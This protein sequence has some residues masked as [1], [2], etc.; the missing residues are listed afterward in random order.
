[1]SLPRRKLSRALLATHISTAAAA[2]LVAGLLLLA[3]EFLSLRR[4]L[5]NDMQAHARIISL[6]SSAAVVFGDKAAAAETLSALNTL[7]NLRAAVIFDANG[8]RIAEHREDRKVIIDPPDAS[9]LRDTYRFGL[10]SLTVVE[11]ILMAGDRVGAVVINSGLDRLYARV[12][13]FGGVFVVVGL[14]GLLASFPLMKRMSGQIKSAE[15]RLDHL[16]HFDPVT[17]LLNRNAFNEYLQSESTA[18]MSRGKQLGLLLLDID[19]FKSV[20]DTFGHQLGDQLLRQI[21]ERLSA[22]VRDGD[23]VFRIGGDEF[24]VAFVRIDS[25]ERAVEIT[26]RLFDQFTRRFRLESQEIEAAVSGGIS[27]Y[28]RDADSI[29]AL[30][31]NA[32]TAMYLAKRNGK[33]RFEVFEAG[34][35]VVMQQRLRVTK[36]LRKALERDQIHLVYQIQADV[37][38]LKVVGVEALLRWNHPEL[39]TVQPKDFIPIAEE[40]GLII[41]L[42]RWTIRAACREASTWHALGI[43]DVRIAVNVSVRQMRDDQLLA[44]IDEALAETGLEPRLLELEITESLLL[45]NIDENIALLKQLRARGINLSIDDFGTGYSSMAYLHQLPIDRLKIDK[46]FVHNIPGDG[47]VITTAIIAMA[48][49]LGIGVIAEGVENQVQLDFLRGADCDVVQG[50]LLSRPLSASHLAERLRSCPNLATLQS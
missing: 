18:P 12:A 20:N 37:D 17:G 13:V 15:A 8:R 22:S 47:E 45:E 16:A 31:S 25:A 29:Q 11:P 39:G 21:A 23:K 4:E 34:M 14:G 2:L 10:G 24:A 38:D 9:L 30:A 42:G 49:R 40:T 3:F 41:A 27:L 1:M 5:T 44:C 50:Y 28:P 6:N 35:N 46:S 43:R 36:E 26:R 32:D 48:H 19:N 33:N 7:S